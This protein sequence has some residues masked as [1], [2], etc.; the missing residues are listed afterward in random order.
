MTT[1]AR[2]GCSALICRTS[3]TPSIPGRRRS[4]STTSTSSALSDSSASSALWTGTTS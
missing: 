2:S 1:T 4:V 3:S